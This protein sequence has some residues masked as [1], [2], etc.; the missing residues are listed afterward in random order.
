MEMDES[1]QDQTGQSASEEA[2]GAVAAETAPEE[3]VEE[4]PEAVVQESPADERTVDRLFQFSDFV[5][6]GPGAEE[7]EDGEDGSCG[8]PLHFHA[9]CRLPNKFQI[10]AIRTKAQAAKAR[11]MRRLKDPESDEHAI[12]EADLEAIREAGKEGM[13]EEVISRTYWQDHLAAMKEVVEEEDSAFA[14]IE[15]D[16]RRFKELSEMPDE[17]RP[18]DEYD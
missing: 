3:S 8:D 2:Q 17:Q 13:I 9:W 4:Q 6:V 16:Q 14:T 12:M 10:A 7:C 15:E 1:M 5:H 11:M 18:K